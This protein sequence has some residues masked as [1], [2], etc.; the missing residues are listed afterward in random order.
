M[1]GG[2]QWGIVMGGGRIV[3]RQ[4]GP[5]RL[6][7]DQAGDSGQLLLVDR[8]GNVLSGDEAFPAAATSR[9]PVVEQTAASLRDPAFGLPGADTKLIFPGETAD[10]AEQ[11]ARGLAAAFAPSP[12]MLADLLPPPTGGAIPILGAGEPV[13]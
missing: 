7:E 6:R 1:A 9:F 12:A 3:F 10:A 11:P 5:R 8:S 2:F 4:V 13:I